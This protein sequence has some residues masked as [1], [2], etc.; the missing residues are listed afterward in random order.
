MRSHSDPRKESQKVDSRS[1]RPIGELRKQERANFL[2]PLVRG[3]TIEADEARDSLALVRPRKI[4]LLARRKEQS[5]IEQEARAHR[6]IADQLS[7]LEGHEDAE[8][9]VPCS[10]EFALR[11]T[12][13]DGKSHRHVCD[14]WET[15]AAYNKFERLY[16]ERQAIDFLKAKYEEQYFN[17]GLVL[18]FSTHKRRNLEFSGKNQ[19]LLVGLIRL[20]ESSQSDLFA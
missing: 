2:A 19:W 16:G 18:G 9:L 11:W 1:L 20:D 6:I 10:H 13:Q 7:L 8:P 15:I 17:A 4:E 14:D 5:Q 3:S 12:D